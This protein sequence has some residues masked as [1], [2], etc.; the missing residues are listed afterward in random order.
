MNYFYKLIL[1]PVFLTCSVLLSGPIKGFRLNSIPKN[2]IFHK[3]GLRNGDLIK[4][5]NGVEIESA[6]QAIELLHSL[7]E[8][9]ETVLSYINAKG[10][11]QTIT[12]KNSESKKENKK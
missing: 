3:I 1:V 2:S 9:K 7:R 12:I 5:I 10:E 6:K 11:V 4:N 8:K